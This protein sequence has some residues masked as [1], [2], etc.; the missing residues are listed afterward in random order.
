MVE[1][2]HKKCI[3]W[4]RLRRNIIDLKKMDAKWLG[5]SPDTEA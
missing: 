3:G 2:F 4:Q 1:A 5:W